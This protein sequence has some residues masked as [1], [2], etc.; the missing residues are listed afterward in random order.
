MGAPGEHSIVDEHD[1][2]I[3]VILCR[4]YEQRKEDLHDLAVV[5][6]R[7]GE[8]TIEFGELKKRYE[9]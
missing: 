3:A 7:R 1:N 5:A 6:E 9:Q 4:E 8:S 2:R